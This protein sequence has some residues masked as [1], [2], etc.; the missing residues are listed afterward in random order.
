MNIQNLAQLLFNYKYRFI[1]STGSEYAC[2]S[3]NLSPKQSFRFFR[4]NP[5]VKQ[6]SSTSDDAAYEDKTKQT[7]FKATKRTVVTE[8]NCSVNHTKNPKSLHM[9]ISNKIWQLMNNSIQ[10]GPLSELNFDDVD[11]RNYI[12]KKGQ[13]DKLKSWDSQQEPES[14]QSGGSKVHRGNLSKD[15]TD[16]G[17]KKNTLKRKVRRQIWEWSKSAIKGNSHWSTLLAENDIDIENVN[18]EELDLGLINVDELKIENKFLKR[19]ILWLLK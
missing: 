7:I 12:I 16:K 9:R 2:P 11:V 6:L 3:H 18:I 13:S 10:T 14:S 8:P 15:A 4:K 19:S 5:G 1:L 17:N